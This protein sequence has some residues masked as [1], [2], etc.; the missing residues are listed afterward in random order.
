MRPTLL[1]ALIFSLGS[2]AT[3]VAD[4]AEFYFR[5]GLEFL[6]QNR[7]A[8]ALD[9]FYTS[10][11]LVRNKNVEL[12]IAATLG[13]LGRYEEAYRAYVELKKRY[14]GQL[15]AQAASDVDSAIRFLEKQVALVEV[16]TDPPGATLFLDRE[17]LGALGVTPK[18]LALKDGKARLLFRL[19]GYRPVEREVMLERGEKPKVHVTLER[20]WGAL[21]AAGTPAG[22]EVRKD[23]PQGELL[24]KLGETNTRVVPGDYVL[25]VGARSFAAQQ[26]RVTVPPD[27]KARIEVSLAELPP[28]PKKTGTVLVQAN[29]ERALVKVDGNEV[30]LTPL[31]VHAEVGQRRFEVHAD[32]RHPD[33]RVVEVVEGPNPPLEARLRAKIEVSGATLRLVELK[34]A[35][36]SMTVISGDELRAFGF[37]TVSEALRSVRGLHVWT[38]RRYDAV[39][40]RGFGWPENANARVL[41]LLNGHPMNDLLRGYGPVGLDLGVDLE[42]VDHIEVV[43]GGG[44]VYGSTAFLGL[45]NVVLKKPVRGVHA[46]GGLSLDTERGFH[47]RG[48]GSAAGDWGYAA[49]Q[50]GLQAKGPDGFRPDG[51]P[52]DVESASQIHAHARSGDFT[53][54]GGL[55]GRDKDVPVGLQW[56][57]TRPSFATEGRAF[58]SLRWDHSFGAASLFARLGYDF[59]EYRYLGAAFTPE[60]PDAPA[61]E[62][63]EVGRAAGLSGELRLQ[64]SY[65]KSASLVAGGE[66]R[67]TF[68]TDVEV[69]HPEQTDQVLRS[70]QL[71]PT[72]YLSHDWTPRESVTLTA[73][74][75][76]D[77]VDVVRSGRIREHVPAFRPHFAIVGQ[78]YEGGST[79]FIADWTVRRPSKRELSVAHPLL[80]R[81]APDALDAE[82]RNSFELEHT[83]ALS[84]DTSLVGSVFV[85]GYSRII[86]SV[87]SDEDSTRLV[88]HNSGNY[89][90]SGTELEIRH[91]PGGGRLV[92]LSHVYQAWVAFGVELERPRVDVQRVSGELVNAPEHNISARFVQ[93]VFERL[94]SAATELVFIG[95]RKDYGGNELP[96]SLSWNVVLSGTY[97]PWKLRY[98]AG[99]FNVLDEKRPD[100]IS[101]EYS[102]LTALRYGRQVRVG[103]SRWF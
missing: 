56:L 80:L 25:W 86:G 50:L 60:R 32:G 13:R 15:S 72:L 21:E 29:V 24:V 40:V 76:L 14:A 33:V 62:M 61:E 65:A 37:R 34:N 31:L 12:N 26:V 101:P 2:S 51:S 73:G 36:A 3:D 22:A 16:E 92:S 8:D 91:A 9:A 58:G 78:P 27:G 70:R 38:D 57:D 6:K 99:V 47:L 84:D 19:E 89:L 53:F 10:N 28:P 71:E 103:L 97:E 63:G 4:E 23:G 5:R 20:I 85:N 41:V 102:S 35:P 11:R 45:V 69:R 95:P 42:Q 52:A 44:M 67:Y 64:W 54:V 66:V 55:S 93:P 81:A 43:R 7:P 77:V 30:G 100:P 39:G 83:H 74:G 90:V 46:Y 82:G 88:Y 59:V 79:K 94:L 96:P 68:F 98:F 1:C 17:D 18:V 75:R 87:R 49:V 48:A